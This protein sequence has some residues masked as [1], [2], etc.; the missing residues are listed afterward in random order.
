MSAGAAWLLAGLACCAAEMLLPGVFLL[1]V[2]LAAFGTGAVTLLLAPGWEAQLLVFAILVAGLIGVV[3]LRLRA[4]PRQTDV[5]NAPAIGLVGATCRAVAFSGAEGRVRLGDGTWSARMA[6]G[7]PAVEGEM[8][9]VV[10][11]D[12]TVLLVV[13]HAAPGHAATN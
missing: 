6:S 5:L 11:L 4:R 1:W 9:R 3:G 12:G 10:G 13:H 2:G 8:L 7:E